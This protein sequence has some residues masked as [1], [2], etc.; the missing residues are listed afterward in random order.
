MSKDKQTTNLADITTALLQ[1]ASGNAA[2]PRL[3]K[4]TIEAGN[5]EELRKNSVAAL[6]R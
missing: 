3:I 4:A 5:S 6:K 1:A 2:D